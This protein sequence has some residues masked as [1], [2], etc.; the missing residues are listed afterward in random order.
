MFGISLLIAPFKAVYYTVAGMSIAHFISVSIERVFH[1]WNVPH[2]ML[3]FWWR[4]LPELDPNNPDAMQLTY[5]ALLVLGLFAGVHFTT[6]GFNLRQ[7]T[8]Q[9]ER[10]EQERR[11]QEGLRE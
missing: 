6:K 2:S 11:W 8:K 3:T 4:Y 10:R 9:V 5:L 1:E 7:R